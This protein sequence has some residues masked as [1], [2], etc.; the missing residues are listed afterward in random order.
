MSI[1]RYFE[2]NTTIDR[3]CDTKGILYFDNTVRN[4]F[5][6]PSAQNGIITIN[7]T[8][9]E[10]TRTSLE[11]SLMS[12]YKNRSITLYNVIVTANGRLYQNNK[13]IGEIIGCWC[14]KTKD[15]TVLDSTV[16]DYV[17]SISGVWSYGIWHFPTEALTALMK[18]KI[19]KM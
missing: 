11:S 4:I 8:P 3:K 18:H 16:Y 5:N 13:K 1:V 17:I 9:G 7:N 2:K 6:T 10:L 12:S 14:D 19:T 15:N